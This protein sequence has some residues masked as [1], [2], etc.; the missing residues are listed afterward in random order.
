MEMP[1]NN[2]AN[3]PRIESLLLSCRVLGRCVEFAFVAAALDLL[4]RQ[5]AIR[6]VEASYVPSAKNAQVA[7]FWLRCGFVAM[8]ASTDASHRFRTDDP[9]AIAEANRYHPVT[10]EVSTLE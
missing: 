5:W 2:L 7:D 9:A 6:C 4:C 10:V 3:S 1:L 8:P